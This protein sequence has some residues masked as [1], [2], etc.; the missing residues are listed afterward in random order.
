[1]HCIV[2]DDE[3]TDAEPTLHRRQRQRVGQIRPSQ[4]EH[5]H[6]VDVK[7]KPTARNQRGERETNDCLHDFAR[8]GEM[9]CHDNLDTRGRLIQDARSSL[10]RR[11]K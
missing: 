6:A 3:H 4:F 1:V 5:E 9:R 7:P 8:E 11:Q 10:E 2:A